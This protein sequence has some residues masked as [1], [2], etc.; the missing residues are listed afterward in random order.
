MV[1][2]LNESD[3]LLD[4]LVDFGADLLEVVG[5]ASFA[6]FVVGAGHG[7]GFLKGVQITGLLLFL[8]CILDHLVGRELPESLDSTDLDSGV[9]GL[10]GDLVGEATLLRAKHHPE[11]LVLLSTDHF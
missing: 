4:N 11:H 7:R 2:E 8:S 1:L 9:A 3:L 6:E 10:G 5:A